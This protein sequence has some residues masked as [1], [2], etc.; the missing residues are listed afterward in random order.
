MVQKIRIFIE[1]FVHALGTLDN[2]QSRAIHSK[3]VLTFVPNS[4][5]RV[6][7]LDLC[8]AGASELRAADS[9]SSE[10]A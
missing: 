9:F 7:E 1:R 2:I 3:H 8:M 5:K 4:G 10:V 6:A